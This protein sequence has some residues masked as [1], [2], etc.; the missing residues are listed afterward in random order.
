MSWVARPG[1][2][3]LSDSHLEKVEKGGACPWVWSD[4]IRRMDRGAFLKKMPKSVLQSNWYYDKVFREDSAGV[5]DYLDLEAHGYEQVPT[6]SNFVYPGNLPDTVAFLR[7]RIAP[8]RL[9]GFLQ[10]SW[11]P[12]VPEHR[13][14]HLEAI[15]MIAQAMTR[16]A[17]P[18]TGNSG[19]R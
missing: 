2:V 4:M 6:G 3:L 17:A 9:L 14:R 16:M 18:L 11:K 7:K 10:T 15:D 19:I 1:S 13:S 5:K 12:A 8:Q